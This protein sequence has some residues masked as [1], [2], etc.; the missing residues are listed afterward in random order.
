GNTATATAT[1]STG[2]TVTASDVN[3]HF[4]TTPQI[5]VRKLT[6]G[7][8]APTAP[9]L[10]LSVG[11]PVTWTYQV[12]DQG[13]APVKVTSIRDD[14]GTPNNPADDFTATAVLQ[15][16]TSFNT[17]DTDQDGLLDPGEVFLFTSAGVSLGS[18]TRWSDVF[19]TVLTY[20]DT[21]GAGLTPG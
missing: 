8:Y 21:S 10:Q 18:P 2:K 15:T 20:T 11:T 6:N 5:F 4:G 7:V 19:Q 1:G 12:T 14:N 3:W 9:G 16:G 13:D 17:G